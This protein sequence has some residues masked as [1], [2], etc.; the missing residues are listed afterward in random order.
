V[1][2][3]VVIDDELLIADV[4]AAILRKSGH[5]VSVAHN[6]E[7]GLLLIRK[8]LPD[9]VVSDIRMPGIDGFQ[10]VLELKA[11][12]ATAQ[13]PVLLMSGHCFADPGSCDAFLAKP[14]RVP[15]LLAIVQRLADRGTMQ[16]QE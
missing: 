12:P 10:L 6:G 15:E 1:A 9:V 5:A 7:E 16:S 13:I 3:V 11:Q 4:C 14:F 2:R 8:L